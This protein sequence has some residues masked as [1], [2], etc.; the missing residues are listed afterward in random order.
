MNKCRNPD[1][2]APV[3][4]VVFEA[5]QGNSCLLVSVKP[6]GFLRTQMCRVSLD[7]RLMVNPDS[8]CHFKV[9]LCNILC[10]SWSITSSEKGRCLQIEVYIWHFG[11][12]CWHKLTKT[13]LWDLF[14][15]SSHKHKGQIFW[16][17]ERIPWLCLL[18]SK[19]VYY[20]WINCALLVLASHCTSA[21]SHC[22][23]YR[24]CETSLQFKSI[25]WETTP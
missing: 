7:H 4:N 1:S 17:V 6:Q 8:V 22:Y 2:R 15:S 19:N 9:H 20:V 25:R 16:E 13:L 10:W 24:S 3:K 18:F 5:L 14:F 23:Y 21:S 11:I 12:K